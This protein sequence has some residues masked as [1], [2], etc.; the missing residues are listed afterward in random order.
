[1]QRIAKNGWEYTEESVDE[2]FK[3]CD[4][5]QDPDE[6]SLY[7]PMEELSTSPDIRSS[8]IAKKAAKAII[9]RY[10]GSSK[11]FQYVDF[12]KK[13]GV[14]PLTIKKHILKQLKGT[15]YE[16]YSTP[17]RTWIQKKD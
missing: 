7:T 16:L 6:K 5:I 13:Y 4:K 17:R 12:A 2:F 1:M 15:G 9:K 11:S 14:C 3:R 10:K 8:V